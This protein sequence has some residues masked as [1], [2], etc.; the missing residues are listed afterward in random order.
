MN[1][2]LTAKLNVTDI[3][4]REQFRGTARFDNID[5]YINNRWQNRRV[6]LALTWN[7]GNSNIKAARE[8]ETGTEQQRVGG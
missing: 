6:N 3:T 8:R 5:M 7:F 4:N 2:K 1:K